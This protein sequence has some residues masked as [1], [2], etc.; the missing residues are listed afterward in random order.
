MINLLLEIK[1]KFL[2]RKIRYSLKMGA[3]KVDINLLNQYST[4]ADWLADFLTYWFNL[5]LK[6]LKALGHSKGTWAIGHSS[7]SRHS[8]G[9]WALKELGDLG[10]WGTRGALRHCG[11]QGTQGTR[12]A[13]G[14]S[15]YLGTWALEALR[16]SKGTWALEHSRNLDIWGT[17]AL[18]EHL[19]TGALKELGHLRHSGTQVTWALE[20]LGHSKG[21]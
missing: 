13:L 2:S 3:F 8:R 18:R 1:S 4:P 7:Y 16:H 10:T 19:G 15:R 17:R 14:P 9:T 11:T 21:T 20:A 6:A 5:T 12:W